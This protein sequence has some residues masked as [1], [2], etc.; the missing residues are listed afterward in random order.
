MILKRKITPTITAAFFFTLLLITNAA[1]DT[2][3]GM[4]HGN[5]STGMNYWNW[6]QTLLIIGAV[7][8]VGLILWYVIS[9]R[10]R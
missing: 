3:Q 5:H 2:Q 8:L 6:T 4:M 10:K 7:C 9:K 1:C